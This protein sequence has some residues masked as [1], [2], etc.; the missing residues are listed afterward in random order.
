VEILPLFLHSPSRSLWQYLVHDVA[1]DESL[2]SLSEL[3]KTQNNTLV[4]HITR[5]KE[6]TVSQVD[7]NKHS[8]LELSD[9]EQL[10][11]LNQQVSTMYTNL[12]F[13]TRTESHTDTSLIVEQLT[14]VNKKL[15]AF[16]ALLTSQHNLLDKLAQ[17]H[18]SDTW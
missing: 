9:S 3:V 4:D 11:D 8:E 2:R 16:M 14:E 7:D 5:H 18:S 17:P 1:V 6:L 12:L 10:G 15:T 13:W